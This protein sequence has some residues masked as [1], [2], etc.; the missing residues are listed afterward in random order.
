M[1]EKDGE[2]ISILVGME[3]VEEELGDGK[4]DSRTTFTLICPEDYNDGVFYLTA[5]GDID[6]DE[7]LYSNEP[8]V[9]SLNELEH[10]EYELMFFR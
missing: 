10:G 5:D 3:I 7:H 1:L 4:I 6:E 8:E 2:E 9:F